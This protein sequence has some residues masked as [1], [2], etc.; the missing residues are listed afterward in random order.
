[1]PRLSPAA[2]RFAQLGQTQAS[3]PLP[4]PAT[5]VGPTPE[6]DL[7]NSTGGSVRLPAAYCG[8]VGFK[9]SYGRL[10]RW[11][12]VA[13]C[14][15]LDTPGFLTRTVGD[16]ALMFSA[17]AVRSSLRTEPFGWCQGVKGTPPMTVPLF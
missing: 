15:S 10:S 5:H 16:A 3:P 6:S 12:L 4:L 14:S 8:L 13:F 17:A 9:P 7:N 2:W 1:M 11:G